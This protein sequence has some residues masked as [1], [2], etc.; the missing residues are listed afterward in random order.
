[1]TPYRYVPST[2]GDVLDLLSAMFLYLPEFQ[3]PNSELDMAGEFLL[4]RE[5]LGIIK[6][7]IGEIKYAELLELSNE[8][9]KLYINSDMKNGAFKL[10]EMQALIRSRN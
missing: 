7:K 2:A 5:S 4:L 3:L 9:E 8:S 6:P 1:M 10:K